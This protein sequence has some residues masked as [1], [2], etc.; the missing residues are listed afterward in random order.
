MQRVSAAPNTAIVLRFFITDEFQY[1]ARLTV[2]HV[3][4][5]DQCIEAHAFD[6]VGLNH[7]ESLFS[8][9]DLSGERFQPHLPLG[10][11]DIEIDDNS[12]RLRP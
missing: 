9:A 8:E 1:V 12:Q 3:A 11:H 4:Y 7:G 2:E 6:F 10:Q 5:L